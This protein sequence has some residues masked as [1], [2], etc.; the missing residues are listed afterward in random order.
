MLSMRSHSPLRRLQRRSD[1]T[2]GVHCGRR[3]WRGRWRRRGHGQ[4][5][6]RRGRGR[7]TQARDGERVGGGVRQRAVRSGRGQRDQR[8]TRQPHRASH[9]RL[10]T[11]LLDTTQLFYYNDSSQGRFSPN[12]R[13]TQS[14]T[15]RLATAMTPCPY[16]YH[17]VFFGRP[18][19]IKARF[20]RR[21]VRRERVHTGFV[22]KRPY[23][24]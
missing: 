4:R 20:Q 22:R 8:R 13:A 10:R 5:R 2:D 3:R 19:E 21:A 1:V 7:R 9:G 24:N 17:E 23:N 16:I 14:V 12:H 6:H 18:C 11:T 15:A